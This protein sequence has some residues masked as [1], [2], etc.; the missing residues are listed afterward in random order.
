MQFF[1][2]TKIQNFGKTTPLSA[3]KSP[4]SGFFPSFLRPPGGAERHLAYAFCP[5]LAY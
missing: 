5:L 4:G 1:Q 3:D 2:F